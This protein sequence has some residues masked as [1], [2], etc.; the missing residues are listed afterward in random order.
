MAKIL[1]EEQ[2]QEIINGALEEIKQ[3]VIKE[4]TSE[5]SWQAKSAASNAVHDIVEEFISKE[6]KPELLV[7]LQKK[8]SAIIDAAIIGA[9]NMAVMLAKAMAE[10]LSENLGTSYKRSEILKAMFD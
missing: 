5:I 1:T 10:K 9:E 2:T 8:K 3:A 6:V 4:A 7:S